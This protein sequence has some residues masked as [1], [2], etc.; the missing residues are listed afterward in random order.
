MALRDGIIERAG[1]RLDSNRYGGVQ[2]A[3]FAGLGSATIIHEAR[4]LARQMKEM[5]EDEQSIFDETL[6]QYGQGFFFDNVDQNWKYEISDL[7][8]EFSPSILALMANASPT[9]GGIGTYRLGAVLHHPE[10]Q[11]AYPTIFRD[12]KVSWDYGMQHH[13]RGSFNRATN[14]LIMN[15]NHSFESQLSTL[16]HEVNHAVQ[17]Y[18]DH[19][20]GGGPNSVITFGTS[21]ILAAKEY[22][23]VAAEYHAKKEQRDEE[24]Q[25]YRKEVKPITEEFS[26]MVFEN[27]FK[28]TVA[29]IA[30][31]AEKLQISEDAVIEI[32]NETKEAGARGER[33]NEWSLHYDLL[34]EAMDGWGDRNP[35]IKRPE[36]FVEHFRNNSF[37]IYQA[38]WGEM[39]ARLAQDRMESA[40]LGGADYDILPLSSF[41][42]DEILFSKEVEAAREEYKEEMGL[43]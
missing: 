4:E 17:T 13:E 34:F 33:S 20:G 36:E 5:G 42:P 27:N 6:N 28:F 30:D 2:I 26:K 25:T 15:P 8:A 43:D 29:E 23:E 3:T 38:Y 21:N 7:N 39:M 10:L 18:E 41:S 24:R 14:E 12:V 19:S 16:I 31:V 22:P 35:R 40:K 37:K 1:P 11:A 32:L 9:T